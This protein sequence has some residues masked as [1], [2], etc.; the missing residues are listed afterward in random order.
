MGPN[1]VKKYSNTIKFISLAFLIYFSIYASSPLLYTYDRNAILAARCAADASASYCKGLH[2]Y[3]YELICSNFLERTA[4]DPRPAAAIF[5]LKK[6]AVL[7]DYDPHKL[8]RAEEA[9]FQSSHN[10]LS[11]GLFSRPVC[12]ISIQESTGDFERLHSGLSPPVA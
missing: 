6:R 5:L 9:S 4:N 2:I 7:S 10:P 12:S 1:G 8:L 3:L 11:E